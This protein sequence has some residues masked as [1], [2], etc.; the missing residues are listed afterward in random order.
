ME[1]PR[2]SVILLT[3]NE[4]RNVGACLASLSDFTLMKAFG[5]A[6]ERLLA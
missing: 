5:V 3:W 6:E 2:L 1:P 4:E